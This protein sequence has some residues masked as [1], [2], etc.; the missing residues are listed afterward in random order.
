MQTN[1]ALLIVIGLL[2]L[3]QVFCLGVIAYLVKR[4]IDAKPI[5][6]EGTT[7][8]PAH[9]TTYAD[10]LANRQGNLQTQATENLKANEHTYADLSDLPPDIGMAA[11]DDYIKGE[12]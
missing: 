8:G 5:T 9:I 11:F 7:A 6:I 2:V 12:K 1:T 3:L 10:A 4:I